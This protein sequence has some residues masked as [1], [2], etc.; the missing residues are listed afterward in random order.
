MSNVYSILHSQFTTII[1]D[2]IYYYYI[3]NLKI[4]TICNLKDIFE[5]TSI[6]KLLRIPNKRVCF[7]LVEFEKNLLNVNHFVC[8]SNVYFKTNCIILK[9]HHNYIEKYRIRRELYDI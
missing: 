4:N 1:A 9:S 3:N 6:P 2:T 8:P 5:H 7:W